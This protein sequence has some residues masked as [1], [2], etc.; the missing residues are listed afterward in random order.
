VPGTTKNASRQGDDGLD[1]VEYSTDRDTKQ[2][3]RQEQKPDNGV[4]DDREQCQGPAQNQEYEP[5]DK[6]Q[7]RK[8]PSIRIL[9]GCFVLSMRFT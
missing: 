5:Q 9:Y 3:E 1:Q 8:P 2:S 7:H 6:G 4:E